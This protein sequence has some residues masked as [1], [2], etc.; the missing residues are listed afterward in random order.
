MDIK[1]EDLTEEQAKT[2][3]TKIVKKLDGLDGDDFFGTEGWK[4]YLGIE[5]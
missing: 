4:H 2:L 3:L 5:D 1:I